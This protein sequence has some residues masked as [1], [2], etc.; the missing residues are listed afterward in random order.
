MFMLRS[1]ILFLFL[2]PWLLLPLLS[3]SLCLWRAPVLQL[4]LLLLLLSLSLWLALVL[5]L[6][7]Q[8][9]LEPRYQLLLLH[10]H[11]HGHGHGHDPAP[12]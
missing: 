5:Q 12:E 6:L 1:V 9:L 10:G 7:L 3:L 11:G 8:Q 4:L 2:C